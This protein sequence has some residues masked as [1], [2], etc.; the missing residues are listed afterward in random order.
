MTRTELLKRIEFWEHELRQAQT[1]SRKPEY[2]GAAGIGVLVWEMDA[3][4]ELACLYDELAAM[5]RAA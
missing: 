5:E 3:R 2:Q 4:R 1:E